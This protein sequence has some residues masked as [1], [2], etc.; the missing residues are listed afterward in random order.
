MNDVIVVG[1]DGSPDADA[2]IAWAAADAA[3]KE[4]RLEL[5]HVI[6]R[7]PYDL[8]RYPVPG[9]LEV[10]GEAA[11]AMLAEKVS[12]VM[13]GWPSVEVA[14]RVMAGSAVAELRKQAESATELV[15]GSRG[16]GG[17]ASALLGSVSLGVAGHAH[18]TVV[19]VRSAP[20]E[21]GQLVVGLSESDS[22]E[23]ALAH[24]FAEASLRRVPLRAVYA[25]AV[26][27]HVVSLDP[28]RLR[29]AQRE[30]ARDRLAPWWEK[31]PEVNVIVDVTSVHPV[32]ALTEASR[33]ADLLVVGNRG[34]G[35][36][37]AAVL[38]SVS[39]GV[40]HHAYCP[41]A[42]VRCQ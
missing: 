16:R 31:H 9:L 21:R 40:L 6:E 30:F 26:P 17:F 38:G 15:V 3:R 24:A 13:A 27:I 22:S 14:T 25:Y 8:P 35:G 11:E 28:D 29:R 34:H 2:A 23:P 18:G 7:G 39:H 12:R 1:T 33:D 32:A 19:V 4:L 20:V 42:V 10:L 36:M 37:A 41:V 5:V